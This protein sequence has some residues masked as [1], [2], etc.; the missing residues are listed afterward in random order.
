M[1]IY[2]LAAICVGVL[3]AC[4]SGP[5]APAGNGSGGTNPTPALEY[6]GTFHPV[7]HEG[8]GMAE[9]YA[10]GGSRELRFTATF[11]TQA[12]PNL[13]VWLIA[14]EDAKDNITVAQSLYV[15]LGVLQNASGEQTYPIPVD[16]DLTQF[17]AVTVWCVSAQVNFTTAPLMM[18]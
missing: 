14:A 6:A 17:R 10:V 13:E 15:S 2:G 1:K 18:Q 3:A 11:A 12:G 8:T 7:A 16:V 4:S 9:I 5:T